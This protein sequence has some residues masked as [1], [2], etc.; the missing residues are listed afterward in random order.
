MAPVSHTLP[1]CMCRSSPARLV[2]DLLLTVLWHPTL[3]WPPR[4]CRAAGGSSCCRGCRC[5]SW[6]RRR[7][8]AAEP[9]RIPDQRGVIR[10]V[11]ISS[12][13][14]TGCSILLAPWHTPCK[15]LNRCCMQHGVLTPPAS[16]CC[17][18]GHK[19]H[20]RSCCAG[21]LQQLPLAAAQARVSWAE[22]LLKRRWLTPLLLYHPNRLPGQLLE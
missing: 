22:L 8:R 9:W 13:L 4:C 5:G 1:G 18:A 3:P 20:A 14:R 16:K 21:M 11:C 19:Y 17:C 10:C 7:W 15:Q 6:C 2:Q 12:H